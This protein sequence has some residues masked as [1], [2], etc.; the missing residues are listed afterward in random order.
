[1]RSLWIATAGALLLAGCQREAEGPPVGSDAAPGAPPASSVA[2]GVPTGPTPGLWRI[3]TR[4]QGMPADMPAQSIE[5]CIREAR[6][7]APPSAQGAGMQCEQQGFRRDGDAMVGRTVCSADG[8]RTVSDIRVTGDF[9]RR[10]LMEVRT[11]MSP[12]PAPGMEETRMTMTAER[13]GDCP[14]GSAAE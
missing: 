4:M 13:L 14:S 2:A 1:M 11:S 9:S 8:M 10:Y 3:T 5:T 6:F 12:A 7:E